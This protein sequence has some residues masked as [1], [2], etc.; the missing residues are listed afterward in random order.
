MSAV[1]TTPL[2][3]SFFSSK[4][5]SAMCLCLLS[6]CLYEEYQRQKNL[7]FHCIHKHHLPLGVDHHWKKMSRGVFPSCFLPS[8]GS[9]FPIQCH[10]HLPPIVLPVKGCIRIVSI[11]L[12]PLLQL[13]VIVKFF[14]QGKNKIFYSCDD[15]TEFHLTQTIQRM[16]VQE[17]CLLLPFVRKLCT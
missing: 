1:S 10:V 16:P 2:K 6:S 14:L 5:T 7:W 4:Q 15:D 3:T 12:Y 8:P 9:S 11:F 17:F 13:T